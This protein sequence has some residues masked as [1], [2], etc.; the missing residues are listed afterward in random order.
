MHTFIMEK[1]L[2]DW[3]SQNPRESLLYQLSVY[4]DCV[5][6]SKKTIEILLPKIGL[7]L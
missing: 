1:S 6:I 3:D 5:K 7:A 4:Y 2:M